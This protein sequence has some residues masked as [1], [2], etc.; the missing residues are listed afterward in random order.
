MLCKDGSAPGACSTASA[1][2]L[3]PPCREPVLVQDRHQAHDVL[4]TAQHVHTA[5]LMVTAVPDAPLYS[6]VR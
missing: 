2:A 1:F 4:R 5:P 3:E 6:L